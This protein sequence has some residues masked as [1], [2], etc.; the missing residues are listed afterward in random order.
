[1]QTWAKYLLI[2]FIAF[3]GLWNVTKLPFLL[4]FNHDQ[5]VAYN[6]HGIEL[7]INLG[8]LV[9]GYRS[10]KMR[11]PPCNFML[12]HSALGITLLAMVILTIVNGERR[13]KYC[14]P[15]FIFAIVEGFHAIPASL[16]N[17]AG[18]KPLFIVAC[19]GLIGSGVWGI[20]TK[21]TY[22]KKP[23]A[24]EKHFVVQYFIICLINIFAAFLE[25]PNVIKA[26]KYHDEHGE[27]LSY[28]DAPHPTVGHTW[29][30]QFPE[31]YGVIIFFTFTCVVW[32]LWPLYL[33]EFA[34]APA[35]EADDAVGDVEATTENT[36]LIIS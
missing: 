28:G 31:K 1:M 18:F 9:E 15:F 32:G 14:I 5:D 33:A 22:D 7:S 27:W 13:K 6:S 19:A 36:P 2:I 8:H 24:A 11:T 3:V 35:K 21:Y 23:E 26:F 30:D 12:V 20:Y 29:Y 10:R 25:T 34:P 16:V 4:A 17:D